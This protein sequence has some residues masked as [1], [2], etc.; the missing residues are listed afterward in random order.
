MMPV[1]ARAS[2]RHG[3]RHP[4]QVLLAALGVALGVAVVTAIDLTEASARRSFDDA[5]QS[6]GG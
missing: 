4:W 3:L 5:A 2:V 6:V 1:L